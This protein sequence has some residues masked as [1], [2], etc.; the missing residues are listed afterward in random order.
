M[1]ASASAIRMALRQMLDHI[2][3]NT[4]APPQAPQAPLMGGQGPGL[5]AP[6][7]QGPPQ[8]PVV[9]GDMRSAMQNALAQQQEPAP[10]DGMQQQD[11]PPTT[12]DEPLAQRARLRMILRRLMEARQFVRNPQE[13]QAIDAQIQMVRYQLIGPGL[14]AD[15]LA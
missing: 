12:P 9:G 10:D 3:Q 14:G 4:Q 15:S 2:G 8:Q 13:A 5:V 1:A 7:P 11:Q 6:P